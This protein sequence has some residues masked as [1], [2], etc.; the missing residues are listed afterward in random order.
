LQPQNHRAKCM[1]TMKWNS[2]AG[3]QCYAFNLHDY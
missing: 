3:F 1:P 2:I